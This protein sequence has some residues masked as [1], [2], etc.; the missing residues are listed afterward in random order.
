MS[1]IDINHVPNI[2]ATLPSN[3]RIIYSEDKRANIGEDSESPVGKEYG[4]SETHI[5][6]GKI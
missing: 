6:N 1:Q 5:F 3:L 2:I 4:I